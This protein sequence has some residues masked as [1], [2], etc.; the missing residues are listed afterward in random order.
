MDYMR[1]AL[2]LAARGRGR[3]SPNPMV[4]AVLVR[5]GR[6]VG[7]GWH[8]QAGGPHAEVFALH[9]AGAAARGA[10]LYVTLEPCCHQGRT[11]PCT[12]ALI[13]AGVAEVHAAMLDANPLVG[14]RGLAELEAAGVRTFL[15][16][17]E[18][19]A[20]L[21][22]EAFITYVT[23]QRPFVIVK[24]AMSL[25]GKIATASGASRGL[26]GAVWQHKLHRLR[27]EVDAILVGVNTALADDPLLTARPASGRVRQPLRVVFDSLLRLPV[28]ARM[29]H[30]S[31]P[32]KT[33]IVTTA[34]ADE[35]KA[36][37]LRRRGAE[38]VR[39]GDATV[40]VT[41]TLSELRRREIGSVLVEGGGRVIASFVAA[42][43]VD[44]VIAVVAPL[45]VGGA[46]APTP[47]AGA[48]VAGLAQA[49][50]LGDVSV[51][52]AGDDI[53]ITAYPQ[54]A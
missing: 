15:G 3:T 21:L 37:A 25:D 53:V 17:H 27:S 29:L 12:R 35:T 54:R 13:A 40:D 24:Y 32:G 52:R 20:R 31:T 16:E 4:G 43:C 34:Q 26:T 49:L 10:T 46:Q 23:K 1:R 11:P 6:I 2:V 50:R 38:V 39:L 19:E 47:M 14:G 7:E 28:A 41:Q 51:Q 8:R 22:N 9:A 44:K 45:M 36:Q 48:G 18:D 30:E 5:D 33:L 42:G